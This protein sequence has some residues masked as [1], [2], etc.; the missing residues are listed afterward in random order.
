MPRLR[1][2]SWICGC[3][4]QNAPIIDEY[5]EIFVFWSNVAIYDENTQIEDVYVENSQFGPKVRD[6]VVLVKNVPL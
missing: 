1:L 5:P 2:I 6:Q 4:D 3:F